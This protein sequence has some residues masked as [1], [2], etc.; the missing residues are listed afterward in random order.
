MV[1]WCN[2][3]MVQQLRLFKASVG[4]PSLRGVLRGTKQDDMAIHLFKV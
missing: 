4:V 3:T 2:G 1:Q